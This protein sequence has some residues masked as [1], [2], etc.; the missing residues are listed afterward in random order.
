MSHISS[1]FL[2]C[3]VLKVR[4]HIIKLTEDVKI[5]ETYLF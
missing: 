3:P 2:F 4:N 1:F 5:P